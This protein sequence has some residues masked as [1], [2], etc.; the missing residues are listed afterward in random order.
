MSPVKKYLLPFLF[1]PLTRPLVNA[2]LDLFLEGTLAAVDVVNDFADTGADARGL[3]L[4][5]DFAVGVAVEEAFHVALK[6]VVG[7]FVGVTNGVNKN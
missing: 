4:D 3:V 2:R 6:L 7:G 5:D 1:L